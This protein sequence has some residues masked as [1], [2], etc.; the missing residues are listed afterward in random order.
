MR[1][2]AFGLD[3]ESEVAL[4]AARRSRGTAD[5]AQARLS[6]VLARR[7]SGRSR[8]SCSATNT[9]PTAAR[10][11]DRGSP[12]GRLSDPRTGVRRAPALRGRPAL[13]CDP[14]GLPDGGWQRLLIAQVLPFAALLHG[15]EVFHA[16]A[17]VHR[18]RAVAFLGPSRFRQDLARARAVRRRSALP[19]RRRARARVPRRAAA[20]TP[21]NA[22]R[23]R[24]AHAR[25]RAHREAD[26]PER[27]VVAVNA[28]E[29]LVRIAGATDP[30]AVGALFFLD[31]RRPTAT[32][33]HA[34]SP[35]ATRKC[36]SPPRST[37]CSPRRR[38]CEVCSTCVRSLRARAWS[39]SSAARRRVSMS[40]AQ[41]SS[42]ASAPHHDSLARRQL[43]SARTYRRLASRGRARAACFDGAR[44][45]AAARRL[46][47]TGERSSADRCACSTASSTTRAELSAALELPA[48][49]PPEE[50]LAAGWRR[51]GRELPARMRGD[52]ALLVWDQERGEGLAR[53]RPAGRAL[54]VPARRRRRAVLRERDPQ[55]AGASAAAPGPDRV[56]VAHWITMG[57]RPGSATLFEG[58]RRLN[59]GAMLLLD[60][61]GAREE[62]YWAPRFIEPLDESGP[63]LAARLRA[64]LEHAVERRIAADG[65]TGVL[66]SGG[67]DSASV[68]AVAATR[69]AGCRV[70]LFGGVP[71]T[72]GG[73]RVRAD[74][75]AA[76][77]A[78]ARRGDGRG[79]RRGPAGE[80]AG[81]ARGVAAAAAQLGRLLGAAAAAR[82]RLRTGCL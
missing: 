21:G 40:S 41:R 36:C 15:L 44:A 43:R 13:Q 79:A 1:T 39:G 60:R 53:P 72:S 63:Q 34:S 48:D 62:T 18:G 54:D 31:R 19:G 70:G 9:S 25:A 47:R 71:G 33:L 57:H 7:A 68:A 35:S 26:L 61:D 5:R 69:G 24:R 16:S 56:S 8:H 2:T 46:Q 17:V 59:P 37:S 14:E 65:G 42:C 50:L 27:D 20:R 45:R 23:R 76:R 73:R 55:P 49:A 82:R 29:R 52:F 81:V 66:M 67:L 6:L 3:V 58:V 51:W 78:G 64:S 11:P 28:R 75:G 10:L 22:R 12:R 30:V 77:Q 80:R 4:V 38:G 74:R 32:A